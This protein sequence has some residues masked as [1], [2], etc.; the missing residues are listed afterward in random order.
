MTEPLNT[1]E[2]LQTQIVANP[3]SIIALTVEA[4][5]KLDTIGR[6]LNA[7]AHVA[8][9]AAIARAERLCDA[10]LKNK[11]DCSVTLY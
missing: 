2:E 4:L 7:V 3:A 10:M 11:S 9:D 1:I 5:S 6:Q 8:R